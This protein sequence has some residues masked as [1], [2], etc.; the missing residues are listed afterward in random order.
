MEFRVCVVHV[1]GK[2]GQTADLDSE[3]PL[4]HLS[5]VPVWATPN[6]LLLIG[7]EG[8]RVR[9]DTKRGGELGQNNLCS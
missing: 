5:G 2:Q 6:S 7:G 9:G 3:E 4:G 8:T 1:G